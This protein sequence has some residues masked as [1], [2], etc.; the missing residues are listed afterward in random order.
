MEGD[1]N[2]GL[3]VRGNRSSGTLDIMQF[4]KSKENLG[5]STDEIGRP[6]GKKKMI[7]FEFL[8]VY[9]TKIKPTT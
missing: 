9:I 6:R 7:L 5:T 4:H 2:N 1:Y 8:V 3:T